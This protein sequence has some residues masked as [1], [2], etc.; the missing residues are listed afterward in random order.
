MGWRSLGKGRTALFTGS[1]LI[2]S[3][4]VSS[5]CLGSWADALK[6]GLKC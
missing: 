5:S 2:T 3:T 6:D 4:F 1:F